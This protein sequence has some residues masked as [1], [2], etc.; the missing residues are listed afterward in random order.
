MVHQRA[1][2]R[3]S[4][5][6]RATLR[7][8]ATALLKHENIQTT[9]AKAKEA[10]RW[11]EKLITLGKKNTNASRSSAQ[12]MIFE[13]TAP[14]TLTKVFGELRERYKDRPGGY[15]RVLRT[16]SHKDDAAE[17]AILSLVDGPRDM[18][19]AMTARAVVR[20]RAEN[21]GMTEI[22][23]MNMRKVTRFR[24]GGEVA[25]EKEV[26]RLK[27][28]EKH[29]R[30][31]GGQEGELARMWTPEGDRYEWA[32]GPEKRSGPGKVVRRKVE[33]GEMGKDPEALLAK[34][35]EGRKW[36]HVRRGHGTWEERKSINMIH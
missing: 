36:R 29:S 19:F 4:A 23:A 3:S 13:E 12:G 34:T 21:K 10:Q 1:L 25:L 6:R 30:L 5:H 18:R 22:L 28:K 24:E 32:R 35:N 14:Y 20:Q 7:N 26:A 9:W 27:R 15:T 17:S 2:S 16:E 31:G 11:V 8:L 33:S